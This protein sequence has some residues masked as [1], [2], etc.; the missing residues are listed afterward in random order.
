L[1]QLARANIPL[2]ADNP[3]RG[4]IVLIGASFQ[5]SRDFFATPNGLMSGL[6]IHAN[7]IHTL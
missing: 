7:I 3:F 6:E 1:A 5:D 2:A 4:K